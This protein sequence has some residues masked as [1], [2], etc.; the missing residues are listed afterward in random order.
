M[1]QIICDGINRSAS[2]ASP[3]L[4]ASAIYAFI[5]NYFSL[6]FPLKE[7]DNFPSSDSY[8]VFSNLFGEKFIEKN[9]ATIRSI[10][11][12]I[13]IAYGIYCYALGLKEAYLSDLRKENIGKK[14]VAIE[15]AIE[16]EILAKGIRI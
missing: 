16:K 7:T 1:R 9:D 12:S 14:W 8:K 5:N 2:H 15:N 3:L 13:P 11:L 4:Y 10:A 6:T